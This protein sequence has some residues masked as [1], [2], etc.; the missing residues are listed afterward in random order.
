MSYAL[1]PFHELFP[2]EAMDEVRVFWVEGYGTVPDGEY[3][4]MEYYCIDPDC[5]CRRV[6]LNVM[7]KETRGFVAAISFGFDPDGP[8]PGPFLDPINPRTDYADEILALVAGILSDEAYVARLGRHYRQV[9]QA[10]ARPTRDVR[11]VM[12]RHRIRSKP[13]R[14]S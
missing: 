3:A 2:D 13:Q 8:A 5:H 7:S 6:L 9:K 10:V 1:C 12:R 11:E 14:G 4:L